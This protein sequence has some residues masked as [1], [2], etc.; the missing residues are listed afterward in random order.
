MNKKILI[1]TANYYEDISQN[2]IKGASKYC[3]SNNIDCDYIEVP[4]SFEIPF[5]I[6]KKKDIYDAFIAL[7][8]VIRGETYHF[9]IISNQVSKKIMDLSIEI[10]KPI[11]FGVL[12][13]ENIDQASIRSDPLKGNKG[14]EAAKA[15]IDLLNLK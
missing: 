8:C 2:L 1:V 4:G 9:E 14:S 5:I 13:C 6:N 10:N 7:G 15:C 12:T 11:G 3:S